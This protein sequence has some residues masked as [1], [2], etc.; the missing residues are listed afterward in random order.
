MELSSSAGGFWKGDILISDLEDLGKLDASEIHPLR[1]NAKEVLIPQ[2]EDEFIF[3]VADGT[4]VLS[5]RDYEF[6]EP[7]PR[8]EQTERSE[9]FQ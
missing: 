2:K 3:P 1:I 5:G 8:R 7:T 9:V 4:A 6:R